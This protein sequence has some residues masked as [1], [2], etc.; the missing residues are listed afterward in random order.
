MLDNRAVLSEFQKTLNF[1][2]IYIKGALVNADAGVAASKTLRIV[3]W[4]IGR[5]YELDRIAAALLAI[6]PDVA[7]LQEVDWCNRRTRDRDILAD[8]ADATGMLG[9]YGVEFLELCSARRS[10]T[11]AGGGAIGNAL[12]SR[13]TPVDSFRIELPL[14]LDWQSD[15]TDRS[16]PWVTRWHLRRERRIGRRFAIGAEF[17]WNGCRLFVCSAHFEDK[18]GGVRGRWSQFKRVEQDLKTRCT[19]MAIRVIAG[20]FNT[21]DSRIARLV[22]PDNDASA[23]GRPT[24]ITEATWWQRAL[25]PAAGYRDPF[26][27]TAWT[28]Q[29]S[30]FF[31]VKL[32]WIVV[33]G[34]SVGACGVGPFASSDHRPIWLELHAGSPG[35]SEGR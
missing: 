19:S 18:L 7:C 24:G 13:L 16:L 6:R 15:P 27:S 2:Q 14:C 31:R 1:D 5:G 29:V 4:N 34:S 10:K 21:F 26:A 22:T 35:A 20:D 12:L 25:L 23:L 17:A 11:L 33:Q 30:P 3:S 28:F 32:D 9:L 8:L